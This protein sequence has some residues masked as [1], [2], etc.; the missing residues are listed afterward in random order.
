MNTSAREV[1]FPGVSRLFADYLYAFE[2]VQPFYPAGSA[3]DLPAL[4]AQAADVA[5]PEAIRGAMAAALA[6]QNP[7]PAAQRSLERF[8]RPGAVAIVTGQQAGLFGGPL[9]TVHKAMTAIRL[10]EQLEAEKVTAVPVFWIASQDHDLAEVNQAW[11]LDSGSV[12]RCLHAALEAQPG[13]PV[14]RVRLP[15]STAQLLQDWEAVTG[16]PAADLRATYSTG[17]TLAQAFAALLQRW[18][19]PWGLLVFDPMEAPEASAVW[20]PYY[21][22]VFQ[23]QAELAELLARRTAE[24]EKA[25]YHAQVEQTAAASMLFALDRG[26]RRGLRRLAD[27]WWSGDRRLEAGEGERLLEQPDQ[28]SPAALL[29]PLLQDVAFPTLAQVTGPAE[30]AYLAQSAVL[31]T[32]FGRRQPVAWPRASATLVDAKARRLLDKYEL[33]LEA[34]WQTPAGELLGER[35]LPPEVGQ[36]VRGLQSSMDQGLEAL[37]AELQRLD[38]TLVDAARGAAEKIQHQLAQLEGRVTRSLTRR[39]GELAA[40][41][42]H[43]EGLLFPEHHLQERVLSGAGFLARHADLLQLLHTSLDPAAA[44]HQAINL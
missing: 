1:R 23:R 41:A 35:A 37:S 17:A 19:E 42:Q 7:S 39:S 24:L 9:L 44:G 22:E 32:A 2:R 18:F 13:V 29:R 15:E 4:A 6:R 25:G 20:R 27:G 5:Y 33:G 21:R 40:Q 43:L 26:V 11:A 14:G 16:E 28:L 10:C 12:P 31:Y 36:R 38:P 34:I 30:T 8:R 3:F